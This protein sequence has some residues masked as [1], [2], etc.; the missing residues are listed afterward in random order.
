[1]DYQ[2]LDG[3]IAAIVSSGKATLKELKTDY[4]LEDAFDLFEI[5]VTDAYNQQQANKAA[6]DK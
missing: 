1:M 4:S 6:R 3:F 5:I 2:N